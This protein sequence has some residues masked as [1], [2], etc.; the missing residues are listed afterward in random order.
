MKSRTTT[1]PSKSRSAGLDVGAAMLVAGG[2]LWAMEAA[3]ADTLAN[4]LLPGPRAWVQDNGQAP[5][6]ANPCV[7]EHAGGVAVV[8][9]EGPITPAAEF[10]RS[11]GLAAQTAE[12]V[13]EAVGAAAEDARTRAVMLRINSPGGHTAGI[14]DLE[15]AMQDATDRVPVVAAMGGVAASLACWLSCLCTTAYASP[16]TLGGNI[17]TIYVIEDS[18]EAYRRAG[19]IRRAVSTGIHKGTG[20]AGVPI[21]D[22]QIAAVQ[23]MVDSVNELF[24]SAVSEGRGLTREKTLELAGGHVIVGRDLVESGLADGLLTPRRV[25][26]AMLAHAPEPAAAR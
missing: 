22:E 17:G 4:L 12:E 19:V 11:W 9:V 10:L 1:T 21:S 20:T 2:P 14:G 16:E 5:W 7:P 23:R 15:S 3:A 8:R 24:I 18:S 6:V 25:L 26:E 13:A